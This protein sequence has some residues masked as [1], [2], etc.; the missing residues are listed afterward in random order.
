MIFSFLVSN[1]SFSFLLSELSYVNSE[2][3]HLQVIWEQF[4]MFVKLY[5]IGRPV[6][7]IVVSPEKKEPAANI[8]WLL[9]PYY[10]FSAVSISRFSPPYTPWCAPFY[11]GN[12][13]IVNFIFLAFFLPVSYW[14]LIS[15]G[16]KNNLLGGLTPPDRRTSPGK[17]GRVVSIKFEQ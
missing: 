7:H 9:V 16:S 1:P 6:C 10:V 17:A 8:I 4:W 14:Q 12:I 3:E 11:H 15:Q 2:K 13:P 5:R